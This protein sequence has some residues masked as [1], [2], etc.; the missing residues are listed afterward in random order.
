MLEG[1]VT[2]R[3]LDNKEN[4]VLSRKAPLEGAA[5]WRS[6]T[7]LSAQLLSFIFDMIVAVLATFKKIEQKI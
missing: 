7:N 2:S 3:N 4:T 1:L 6:K 5:S